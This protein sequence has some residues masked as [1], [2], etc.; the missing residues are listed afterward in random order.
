MAMTSN[1]KEVVD[2]GQKIMNEHKEL[3]E[4]LAKHETEDANNEIWAGEVGKTYEYGRQEEVTSTM[5]VTEVDP[6]N[7][8]VTLDQDVKTGI[9]ADFTEVE[10][11]AGGFSY[12]L[13]VLKRVIGNL[14]AK[15]AARV[16]MKIAEF[17]FGESKEVDKMGFTSPE[18]K[19]AFMLFF[20]INAMKNTML[21]H[22]IEE[23][24]QKATPV[25]EGNKDGNGN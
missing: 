11:A 19:Q 8:I 4:K 6:Q 24:K 16:V 25:A 20:E 12:Y 18:E 23:E 5:T 14:S 22:V 15:A 7:K 3:F 9:G 21:N 2:I 17:P 13:P 1:T 10:K